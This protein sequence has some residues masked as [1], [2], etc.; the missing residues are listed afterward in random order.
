MKA[1]P[2]TESEIIA[3]L[4]KLLDNFLKGQVDD[5]LSLYSDEA[6]VTFIGAEANTKQIGLENIKSQIEQNLKQKEK[7][8]S[9]RYENLLVSGQGPFAWISADINIILGAEKENVNIFFR[10]TAVFE[11]Q[12]DGWRVAQ[13]HNSIPYKIFE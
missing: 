1:D 2:K 13:S 8:V 10:F 9:I 6:D 4:D 7:I 12:E 5:I 3:V 11:R